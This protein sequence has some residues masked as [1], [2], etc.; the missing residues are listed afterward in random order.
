MTG[1]KTFEGIGRESIEEHRQIH[2]YL[3]QIDRTLELLGRGGDD[4]EQLQRLAAQ[5]EGLRERLIEHQAAEEQGL[6]RAVL[7]ALP[8]CRVELERLINEHAKMI[9]LLEMA[10]IHAERTGPREAHSLRD[11]LDGFLE[12]FRRHEREEERLLR[13]AL[14][15]DAPPA[16]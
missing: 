1:S 8:E 12:L 14:A 2:F 10:S 15:K 16:G 9:E 4:D 5:I 7:E 13:R 11:D 6:F 3:D